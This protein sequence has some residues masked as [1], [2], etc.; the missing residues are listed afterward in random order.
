MFYYLAHKLPVEYVS[1]A[2]EGECLNSLFEARG[3]ASD[4]IPLKKP[5]FR[6]PR[7]PCRTA[8]RL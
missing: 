2:H 1:V 3:Q 4:L 5:F 8:G 7:L 6:R